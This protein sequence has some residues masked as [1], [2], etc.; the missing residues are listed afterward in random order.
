[1]EIQL[2]NRDEL[3]DLQKLILKMLKINE[4]K[5]WPELT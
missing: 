3:S 1:M 4:S 2:A 5:Y